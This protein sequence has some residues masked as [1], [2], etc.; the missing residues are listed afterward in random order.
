MRYLRRHPRVLASLLTV[1]GLALAGV[2]DGRVVERI[3]EATSGP[4]SLEA[5]TQPALLTTGTPD[6]A[7]IAPI[8][9]L[10]ALASTAPAR[11]VQ[12]VSVFQHRRQIT[13]QVGDDGGPLV[14]NHGV[15]L[16]LRDG[17]VSPDDDP[18]VDPTLL[19]DLTDGEA[20]FVDGVN[21]PL[22]V[23]LRP[24]Y[25]SRELRRRAEIA[26]DLVRPAADDAPRLP[27]AAS[28]QSAAWLRRT[29]P[30]PRPTVT[31]PTIP[32]DVHDPSYVAVFG[33]LD[34]DTTP[35]NVTPLV[36]DGKRRR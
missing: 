23:H 18:I 11:G 24:W 2:L 15:R 7:G 12:L 4:R 21:D 10:A 36:P 30:R 31:D 3:T 22:R 1:G 25:N 8:Y 32:L 28:E 34:D 17:Q 26:Q 6:V 27:V 33:E 29:S 13:E 14:R 20:A 16:V 35:V 5:T 9:D 19:R